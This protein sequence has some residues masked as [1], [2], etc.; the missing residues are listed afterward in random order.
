MT[1]SV[2]S[3]V[4][5]LGFA[6]QVVPEGAPVQESVMGWLNP[7][8]GVIVSVDVPCEPRAMVSELGEAE[9]VK[10]GPYPLKY[11]ICVG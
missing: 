6:E 2:P 5:V 4:T 1:G 3:G 10:S 7:A 11:I 8:L 9:I